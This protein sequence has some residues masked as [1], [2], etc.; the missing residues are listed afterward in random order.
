M[1][2]VQ[3]GAE[4]ALGLEETGRASHNRL[5]DDDTGGEV[6]RRD[7]ADAGVGDRAADRRLVGGPSGRADDDVDAEPRERLDVRFHGVREREIDRHV[8][9]APPPILVESAGS[10]TAT[11]GR[12]PPRSRHRIA[13]QGRRPCVPC[14]RDRRGGFASAGFSTTTELTGNGQIIRHPSA[15]HA[16]TFRAVGYRFKRLTPNR[17]M[18]TKNSTSS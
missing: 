6:W 12:R 18:A 15:E 3:E 5:E 11:A 9:A 7:H 10:A 16:P 2:F 13:G 1:R 17:K 4:L 14:D 8:D